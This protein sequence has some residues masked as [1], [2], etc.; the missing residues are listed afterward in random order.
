[1]VILGVP[2]W[3]SVVKG[4]HAQGLFTEAENVAVRVLDVKVETGPRSFFQRVDH[5]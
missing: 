3:P 4:S 2:L 5:L 1:L